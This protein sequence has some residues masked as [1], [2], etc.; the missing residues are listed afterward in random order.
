[1]QEAESSWSEDQNLKLQAGLKT[2]GKADPERWVKIASGV[3][4][5][6]KREANTHVLQTPPP[7][8]VVITLQSEAV[9]FA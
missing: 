7:L 1:M 2:F 8:R 6:T 3:P 9:L 5:K 4:N